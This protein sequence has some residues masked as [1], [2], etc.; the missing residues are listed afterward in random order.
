MCRLCSRIRA[1][2]AAPCSAVPPPAPRCS[3]PASLTADAEAAVLAGTR[4]GPLPEKVDVVVVGA[5]LAGLVA[6]RE[7]ARAGRSVLVVEARK[8]VGG[9]VLN[10]HLTHEE[11]RR[12]G[13]RVRR[14]LHR[15]DPEPH[16]AA[17]PT[18]SACR[19]SWST[20][21]AT[22]STSPRRSAGWSTPAPSRPTRRSS[23]DAALLLTQ[24]DGYAAEIAVDAPVDAPA[25]ARVGLDHARPVDPRQRDQRRRRREPHPLLDPARLRRRPERALLPLRAL[26]R[27]VLGRRA[28]HG[29]VLA[30]LRH[31]ERRPGAPVRRRL[32]ADP[33]A[34]GQEARRHRRRCGR[35][36]TGS[37]RARPRRTSAPAAERRREAGH[38]RRAAADR[39]R[40]RLFTRGCPPTGGPC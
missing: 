30:E 14:R 39:A 34:A 10:H 6:A 3:A 1:S 36:C 23:P 18:S 19:R 38:R 22:A 35:R 12:P 15:P 27:R 4:Q 40:H 11:A 37:S 33:A 29:H 24:I 8:R 25:G 17:G 31:R 13:H 5:G 9:R 21:P 16:R 7:V 20:T 2:P 28:A 32:A 26:V